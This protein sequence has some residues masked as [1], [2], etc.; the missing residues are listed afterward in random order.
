M[1]SSTTNFRG[2]AAL[3]L[4]TG[5]LA[6]EVTTGVGPRITS[7]RS[8]KGKAG[9]LFLEFPAD[10]TRAQGYLLRGGHRLWH[11]PEHLVRTYQPDDE[12]CAVK[13]VKNGVAI[14]QPTE[15]ATGL[16]KALKI[17]LIGERTIRVT[18]AL[19]N[20]GLW[21]VETACWA[22]TMFRAG[23]Y[24]V[25]PLLPKGSHAAGDLLPSYSLVPWTYTDFSMDVWDFHPAYIG[26][27]VPAATGAQKLGITGY[28]GWSAYYYGGTTFVKSAPVVAGANYPDR[29][30]PFELFTN[31]AMI[32]L[33]TLSPLVTLAPGDSVQHV[34]HWTLLD[35][36][37]EPA[38][39][40]AFATLETA[41]AKWLKT[42]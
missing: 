30:C 34:E 41:V 37:K 29:G 9:N 23:G 40:G 26:V 8:K 31:G 12:P 13:P 17:E 1:K 2:A 42:L 35:G 39:D 19:T 33:E 28:P 5:A 10:E 16:Q 3:R 27:D 25:L 11:A 20:H 36:L 32:E 18:H 21:P 4:E 15:P 38:T 6:L 22:L 24:G 14:A 7:L